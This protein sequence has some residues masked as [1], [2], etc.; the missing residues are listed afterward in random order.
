V[1]ST[2]VRV[3]EYMRRNGLDPSDEAAAGAATLRGLAES[4]GIAEVTAAAALAGASV[5]EAAEDYRQANANV[6]E[7]APAPRRR[8]RQRAESE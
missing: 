5:D 1:P 2:T 6:P 4:G 3:D 8:R 7:D